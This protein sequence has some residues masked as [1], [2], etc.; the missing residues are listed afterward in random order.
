MYNNFNLNDDNDKELTY[1]EKIDL[2]IKIKNLNKLEHIEILKIL[3]N[4]NIK[5]T[6]NNNGVFFNLRTLNNI[7]LN[8]INFF[9]NYCVNNK[10]LFKNEKK[11]IKNN[12]L[13]NTTTNNNINNLNLNYKKY[14]LN[15]NFESKGVI[16]N[17][18]QSQPIINS[19]THK[20]LNDTFKIKN[21]ENSVISK[22]TDFKKQIKLNN[23]KK[24]KN[25]NSIQNKLINKCK[26]IIN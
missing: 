14:L 11:E 18:K 24:T 22:K 12:F 25:K 23:K 15:E 8:K 20:N 2:Q 9:V 10:K 7:V 26:K 4:D 1:N 19:I 13:N 5:Y 21:I 3:I 6:E 16:N 17:D